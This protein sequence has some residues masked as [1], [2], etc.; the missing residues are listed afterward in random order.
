[1]YVCVYV[2]C[3]DKDKEVAKKIAEF[4]RLKQLAQEKLSKYRTLSSEMKLQVPL[5]LLGLIGLSGL[6]NAVRNVLHNHAFET[7]NP[8]N[9]INL[10]C[11]YI[12]I[13]I[14]TSFHFIS[15]H[16]CLVRLK[17]WSCINLTTQIPIPH[18]LAGKVMMKILA[19]KRKLN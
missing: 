7:D 3:G 4:N 2:Q 13:L 14:F 6:S 17:Y 8:D 18:F 9:P 1:M 12:N 10:A 5:G 15:L 19:G 11:F 16:F